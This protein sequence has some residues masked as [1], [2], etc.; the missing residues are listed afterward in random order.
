MCSNEDNL[1][2]IISKMHLKCFKTHRPGANTL[3]LGTVQSITVGRYRNKFVIDNQSNGF[4]KG[5]F[6][7]QKSSRMSEF[8]ETLIIH[9]CVVKY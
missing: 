1:M 7:T 6:S 8:L 4:L 2:S 3:G 5:S 9:V